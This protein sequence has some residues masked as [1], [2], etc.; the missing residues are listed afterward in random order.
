MYFLHLLLFPQKKT[1][2]RGGK[3]AIFVYSVYIHPIY[4]QCRTPD[5]S[6][7]RRFCRLFI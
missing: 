2:F 7:R 6:P 5:V 3:P 1:D 4:T